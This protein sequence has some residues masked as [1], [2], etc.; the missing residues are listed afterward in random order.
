M[1]Y[2][3]G[4]PWYTHARVHIVRRGSARDHTTNLFQPI[5]CNK[6]KYLYRTIYFGLWHDRMTTSALTSELLKVTTTHWRNI[7]AAKKFVEVKSANVSGVFEI[8]ANKGVCWQVQDSNGDTFMV[9]KKQVVRGPWE[10]DEEADEAPTP[11][12]LLSQALA[13]IQVAPAPAKKERTARKERAPKEESGEP[14]VTLKELCFD[15]DV[16]PRIARRRLRKALGNIGTGSRWEWPLGSQD[17]EKVK[18]VLLAKTEPAPTDDDEADE[19]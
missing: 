5:N 9:Q 11:A 19:E 3:Q 2:K 17:L 18:Q 12:P 7:M 8:L 10:E 6:E 1:V 16:I 13:Q 15:L 14:V 4:V